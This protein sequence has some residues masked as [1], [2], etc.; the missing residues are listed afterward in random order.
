MTRITL[1]TKP[2]DAIVAMVEGNP[3]ALTVCMMLMGGKEATID[4]QAMGFMDIC[5]LDDQEIYGPN[6]WVAYKD[7]CGQDIEL[8]R[9]KIRENHL[10]REL[11]KMD[12]YNE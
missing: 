5:R 9:K 11:Q 1:E 2:I 12:R 7:L 3:G 8:L 4:E 10:M 6:I